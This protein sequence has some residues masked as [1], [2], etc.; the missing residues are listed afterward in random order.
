MSMPKEG[1]NSYYTVMTPT[2]YMINLLNPYHPMVTS[3]ITIEFPI[4]PKIGDSE[5]DYV[6]PSFE[7]DDFFAYTPAFRQHLM[8]GIESILYPTF[9]A[10]RD[11][12]LNIVRLKVIKDELLWRQLVSLYL[13]HELTVVIRDLKDEA[14]MTSFNGEVQE[15]NY[16]IP[17]IEKMGKQYFNHS[18]Y[19]IRFWLRYE[20]FANLHVVGGMGSRGR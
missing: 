15:K 12:A 5:D 18:P 16:Y 14:N 4:F 2:Q 9:V 3:R 20:P 6:T 1:Y 7:L 10:Y 13:A 11:I 19:G 17:E 8:E